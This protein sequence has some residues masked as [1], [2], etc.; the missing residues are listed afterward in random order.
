[1]GILCRN[2]IKNKDTQQVDVE[3]DAEKLVLIVS[4]KF[5]ESWILI[6][7]SLRFRRFKYIWPCE[8]RNEFWNFLKNKIGI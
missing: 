3:V 6:Q 5:K 2:K 8:F 1:M 7:D 4:D